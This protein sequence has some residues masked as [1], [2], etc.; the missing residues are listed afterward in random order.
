MFQKQY[1]EVKLLHFIGYIFTIDVHNFV[2][3]NKHEYET[4]TAV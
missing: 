4:C 3:V 2:S 1:L